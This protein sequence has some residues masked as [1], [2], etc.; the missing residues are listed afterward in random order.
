MELDYT[1]NKTSRT[2]AHIKYIGDL[3]NALTK[4]DAYSVRVLERGGE[5]DDV[6]DVPLFIREHLVHQERLFDEFLAG[7]QFE[8]SLRKNDDMVRRI[9]RV[10]GA[11]GCGKTVVLTLLAN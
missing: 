10:K 2:T 8:P 4:G 5:D 1:K 6:K 7:E 9:R 3:P 11:P